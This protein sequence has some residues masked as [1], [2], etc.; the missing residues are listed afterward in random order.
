MIHPVPPTC[1]APEKNIVKTV[2]TVENETVEAQFK[3]YKF[4][5]LLRV[6]FESN[7]QPQKKKH[8]KPQLKPPATDLRPAPQHILDIDPPSVAG[9]ERLRWEPQHRCAHTLRYPQRPIRHQCTVHLI[10]LKMP[11]RLDEMVN[12]LVDLTINCITILHHLIPITTQSFSL[13]N[14]LMK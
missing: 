7:R 1:K 14:K 6:L 4:K 2:Q 13:N 9:S 10:R 5:P 8:P 11:Q 12:G 3:L